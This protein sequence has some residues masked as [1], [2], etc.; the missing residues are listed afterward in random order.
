MQALK[1]HGTACLACGF[2][3]NKVYGH[4]YARSYIEV[5]HVRSITQGIAVPDP[6]KDLAPLC[7]NCHSMAHRRKGQVLGV[8]ELRALLK[9]AADAQPPTSTFS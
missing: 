6:A 7:S 8:D 5:H 3:F 2:D 9:A 1:I 4:T